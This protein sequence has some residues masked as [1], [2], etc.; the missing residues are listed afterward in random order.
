[1]IAAEKKRPAR[2]LETRLRSAVIVLL[3]PE[4]EVCGQRVDKQFLK[5]F[6]GAPDKKACSHCIN[7]YAVEVER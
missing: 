1:M 6:P 7:D 3:K 4:C 2:K 5:P